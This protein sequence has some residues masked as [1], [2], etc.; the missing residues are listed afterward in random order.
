MGAKVHSR[1]GNSP[2]S[3]L[4]VLKKN[5]VDTKVYENFY[6]LKA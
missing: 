1:E 4:K 6:I 2:E 5:F 3:I